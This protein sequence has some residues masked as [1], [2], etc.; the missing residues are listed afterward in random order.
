[1]P[2]LSWRRVGTGGARWLDD[3]G[4]AWLI[5]LPSAAGWLGAWV[6]ELE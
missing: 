2:G 3:L 1:M 6:L 4:E 5:H